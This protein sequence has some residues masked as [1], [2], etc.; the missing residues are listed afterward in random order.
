M[1]QDRTFFIT[2]VCW[3]RRPI[4]GDAALAKAFV[5]TLYANRAKGNLLLHEFVVMPDHIH[6]L[7]TPKPTLALERVMQF[8]K[9]G[10]SHSI[11]LQRRIEVWQ[12]SFTNQRI[13]DEAD[14]LR[15]RAYIRSNP[16]RAKLSAWFPRAKARGFHG[17]A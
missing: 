1:D 15:H 3:Q 14:Y 11:R 7:I 4:F 16:V 17:S 5:E 13:R 6:L 12:P 9:G 2:S 10:F 8:I